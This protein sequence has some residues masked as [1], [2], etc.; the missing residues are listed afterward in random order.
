MYDNVVILY[1]T[2]FDILNGFLLRFQFHLDFLE[3]VLIGTPVFPQDAVGVRSVRATEVLAI[4]VGVMT[5]P[6]PPGPL[7]LLSTMPAVIVI[8]TVLRAERPASM[9]S[10]GITCGIN[11]VNAMTTL[12]CKHNKKWSTIA[13]IQLFKIDT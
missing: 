12:H 9:M 8:V 4:Q 3:R 5:E 7:E 1:L 2:Y 10:E 6:V 13:C 11:N